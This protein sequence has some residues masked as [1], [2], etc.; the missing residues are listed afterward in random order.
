MKNA[1]EKAFVN[2][3]ATQ[4]TIRHMVSAFAKAL[5][6]LPNIRKALLIILRHGTYC[7][8]NRHEVRR[9]ADTIEAGGVPG[10]VGALLRV[11]G[12]AF[13]ED[14]TTT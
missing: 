4:S 2:S 3:S 10:L 8:T 14:A 11:H 13:R 12:G 6:H 1:G 7:D 5:L 9:I